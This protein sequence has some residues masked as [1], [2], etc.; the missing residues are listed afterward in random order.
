MKRIL[1]YF[2]ISL[3]LT[4]CSSDNATL[5]SIEDDATYP[6]TINANFP[7]F[8]VSTIQKATVNDGEPLFY[9][10]I[11]YKETGEVFY[12]WEYLVE[13]NWSSNGYGDT[14]NLFTFDGTKASIKM[15]FPEGKYHVGVFIFRK[16]ASHPSIN[17]NP[18]T[19]VSNY[20]SD[21]Y[22]YLCDGNPYC[23]QHNRGIY[24]NTTDIAIVKSET[25]QNVNMELQPMWS[26][27]DVIIDDA[28]TFKVPEGTNAVK[29][30]VNPRYYGFTVKTK[31]GV[32]QNE[33]PII[34]PLNTIRANETYKLR[35]ITTEAPANSDNT[36]KV[37]LDYLYLVNDSTYTILDTRNLQMTETPLKNGKTY[38]IEGKLTQTESGLKMNISKNS[39][40][41][42][43]IRE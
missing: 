2:S 12:N 18:L 24:F 16:D 38:E 36:I 8:E 3:L 39:F 14:T 23:D 35:V 43:D 10:L 15:S 9:E 42:E 26:Y 28:K 33:E 34:V 5:P 1:L 6:V 25:S 4:A 19:V 29:F 40:Y 41:K 11:I 27:I 7:Q 22:G 13:E 21:F 31:L 17:I 20:D 32:Y 37:S 30:N